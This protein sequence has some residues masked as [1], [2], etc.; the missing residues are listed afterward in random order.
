VFST[1]KKQGDFYCPISNFINK[2]Y[3]T[4]YPVLPHIVKPF[5][6]NKD[7]LRN[8]LHIPETATVFG[9]YGGEDSFDIEFVQELIVDIAE[10][11]KN[12]YFLFLNFKSF[13]MKKHEN[14]VFLPKNTDLE[15]KEKFINSC[16]A[17]IHA[18]TGGETFGLAVAE[19]SI[20]NKPVITFAPDFLHNF[21]YCLKELV[22]WIL[23]RDY[24]YATAHLDFLGKKAIKYTS[25][26]DLSIIFTNFNNYYDKNKNYDC[27]SEKF[28]E[29]KVMKMFEN[30]IGKVK[31]L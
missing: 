26:K 27:Y 11:H 8:D 2:W 6:G 30:I 3:K 24:R 5:S 20:K 14:I 25:K 23:N 10:K 7:N 28:N 1:T 9:G 15:Y 12:I 13:T 17:M 4:N 16:T 31:K 19:F 18:R 22:R 21:I 29:E